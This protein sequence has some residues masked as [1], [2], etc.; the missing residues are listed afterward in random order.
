MVKDVATVFD[1]RDVV[2]FVWEKCECECVRISVW[3]RYLCV[4]EMCVITVLFVSERTCVFIVYGG[5]V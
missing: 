1:F 2:L 3:S 4:S 5:V